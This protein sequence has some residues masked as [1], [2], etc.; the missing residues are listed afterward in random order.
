MSTKQENPFVG[1]WR[2]SEMEAWD[3]EFVDLIVPGFL[4]FDADNLGE[5]QFGAVHGFLDCRLETHG[6]RPRLE[7]SWDGEDDA[8]PACGRGWATIKNGVISGHIFIHRG[9]DSWFKAKKK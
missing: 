3:Q 6:E 1:R 9:D 2:I 8:D 4:K 5:F 7:F